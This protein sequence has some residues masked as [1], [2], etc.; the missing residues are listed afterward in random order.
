MTQQ[1]Q[2][3]LGHKP[4]AAD[5]ENWV[6][7]LKY[8]SS[9]R[10]QMVQ[11]LITS[12]AFQGRLDPIVRL[13]TAYFKRLPDYQGL[14]YWYGRMYPDSGAGLDLWQVA[15]AFAQSEE[16]INT[17]GQLN[18]TG[19]ITRLY[20]NVL[21][22][23]PEP[24]GYAYWMG[25]LNSGM[26]RGEVMVGFS[27]SAENQQAN[28]HSQMV[29]MVYV[30]MLRRVPNSLEHSQWLAQIQADPARVLVLIDSVLGSSEYAARF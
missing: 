16:F 10:A 12:D 22:R 27:E 24:D 3:F 13:Y 2:D 20:Q 4:D 17:Y 5:L 7:R 29:T 18:N 14:M 6:N 28:V 26:T 9:T 1:Y 30:G 15:D 25:R 19:F 23:Q 8:G 21:N 11:S